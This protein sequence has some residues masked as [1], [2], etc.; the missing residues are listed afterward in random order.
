[1]KKKYLVIE[2]MDNKVYASFETKKQLK[3][4]NL[5][6]KNRTSVEFEPGDLDTEC[7]L[8]MYPSNCYL[9]FELK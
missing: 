9:V 5:E 2:K 8:E 1:M 6:R 3:N 7:S 4:G